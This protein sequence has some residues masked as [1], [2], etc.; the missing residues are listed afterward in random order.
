MHFSYAQI[1]FL[2]PLVSSLGLSDKNLGRRSIGAESVN[3]Y[4][5]FFLDS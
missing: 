3:V 5:S 4:I 2:I 1:L